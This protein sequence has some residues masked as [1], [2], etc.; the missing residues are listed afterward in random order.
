[1][2]KGSPRHTEQRIEGVRPVVEALRAGRRKVLRVQL[3]EVGR[4]PGLREL[5][6]LVTATGVTSQPC[7]TAREICAWAE[8]YPECSFEELLVRAGPHLLIA[9]DQVTDVGN[10]GSIARS[11][12]T[13]GATGLVL[14]YRKSGSITPGAL[15]AS[16]GALEHLP[17]ARTPHLKRALA[18]AKSEGFQVLAADGAGPPLASLADPVFEGSILWVFGSED[19]GV[20]PSLLESANHRVGIPQRGRIASLGVA[21]AAAVLLHQSSERQ[22]RDRG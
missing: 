12:E 10:L 7:E 22:L 21:A 1:M 17:V 5:R 8:P 18:I 3:P 6:E 11:A 15:R 19:R 13:A 9:L 16:A 20:R 14:E 4:S 2:P